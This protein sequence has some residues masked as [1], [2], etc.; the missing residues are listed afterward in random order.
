MLNSVWYAHYGRKASWI[1]WKDL[2]NREENCEMILKIWKESKLNK[3]TFLP[4]LFTIFFCIFH[5]VSLLNL[6]FFHNFHFFSLF[7]SIF[8]ISFH[9]STCLSSILSISYNY[10]PFVKRYEKYGWKVC[11]IVYDMHIM[12]ERQVELSEKIW[13]IEKKIV[14]WYW[15]YGFTIEL[16]FLS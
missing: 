6:S 3:L 5:I 8:S 13:K 1:K 10:S 2:E 7:S 16:I 4:Y 14:K 9:Y 12:E 11:W 15:K